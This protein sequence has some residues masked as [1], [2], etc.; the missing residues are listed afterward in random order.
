MRDTHEQG[1]LQLSDDDRITRLGNFL[2][3]SSIDEVPQIINILKGEMSFVGPRPQ[4]DAFLAAM[5][6]EEKRRHDV[7]PGIT[8]WA[9]TH[10]RNATEWKDRFAKD[11]W[12]VENASFLLDMRIIF[13]TPYI[14]VRASGISKAGYVTMPTL[15]EERTP[16]QNGKATG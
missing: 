2:R 9:Q 7:L 14:V 5:T 15:F 10:G 12:Y 11:L 6:A 1:G 4:D 8:G 16:S 3:R 13:R